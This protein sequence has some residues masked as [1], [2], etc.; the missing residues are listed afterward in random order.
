MV[1]YYNPM[2]YSQKHS[3]A[4]LA[5]T[6]GQH[7]Q[8][9]PSN[10][11]TLTQQFMGDVDGPHAAYQMHYPHMFHPAPGAASE[12]HSPTSSAENFSQN[13]PIAHQSMLQ[14]HQHHVASVSAAAASNAGLISGNSG[15][16]G[17]SSS[18]SSAGSSTTPGN[19]QL[20]ETASSIG[21][22]HIA[23]GLP[24]PPITVSGSEI[25]SPGA[26][27]S[28]SSPHHGGHHLAGA[29]NNNNNN[30]HSPSTNHNNNNNIAHNNN[31]NHNNRSSPLK[32]QQYF[33][34]MKK[35]TYPAQPTPGEFQQFFY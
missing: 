14:Q 24:S 12:W 19:T 32:G 10:Y 11:H 8:W 1:S 35:P 3:A 23:E 7:W 16:A 25:S 18:A 13:A 17:S 21:D 6:A 29:G 28:S 26:P 4:N 20:N 9:S 33:D 5:Y 34:W 22:P 31:N 15:A 30:N 2:P 27:A